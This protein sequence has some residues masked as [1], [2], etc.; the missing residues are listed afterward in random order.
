MS[1]FTYLEANV[2]HAKDQMRRPVDINK[3][4]SREGKRPS[5]T[6]FGRPVYLNKKKRIEAAADKEVHEIPKAAED[7][8]WIKAEKAKANEEPRTLGASNRG[9]GTKSGA[10]AQKNRSKFRFDWSAED[11]TTG[12]DAPVVSRKVRDA[13][14]KS[15]ESLEEIYMGKHWSQKA[16]EEMSERDWRI[17]REDYHIETKGG[18]IR[19][20]LRNWTETNSIPTEIVGIIETKLKYLEPTPIQRATI[21]N[22]LNGRDFVGVAATGSGKTLAFLIPPLCQLNNT[23]PL[24]DITKMDGPSA[25]IL[26]PTRELAQQIEA[27]A[28]KVVKFLHRPTKVVSLVGGHSVEE[29]SYS[30]SHGCDILVAT[31]GRLIDC[32]ESNILVLQQVR[33]LILDEADRMIDFGFE[34]QLTTILARTE[35][36]KGRQTMMFTATMSSTIER[37][38][39]GY[40]NKPAYVRVGS[41]DTKAQ[42][43]QVVQYLPSEEQ[44]FS[45]LCRDVLPRF[46][47]PIMIFINYKRTA[48][49]LAAKFSSETRY[50]VTTLHGSKS[51]EQREHSLNLLRSG[52]AD[53]MIA[54]DVAGRGIDIPNVSLVVNFQMCTS[55]EGYIHRIGRTGRAGKSGC[56]LTFLT[57]RDEPKVVEELFHYVKTTDTEGINDVEPAV[58]Q[59]FNLGRNELQPIVH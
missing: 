53:I 41:Q 2:P 24:N 46:R 18:S 35:S 37:I 21:P 43:K 39:N 9:A 30:L 23:P 59:K 54:T 3:L 7:I 45:R 44:R 11:D 27:E 15:P 4:I 31:P 22:V 8:Q 25:L 55:F 13:A 58:R 29:I 10:Y 47:S 33:T 28:N 5:E 51:Q 34:D 6:A 56:A 1:H 19:H 57:E 52:K 50:R 49:W 42:I 48:D 20:P 14:R 26:A 16:L 32:L 38:A 12:E 17:L 36:V 40:L